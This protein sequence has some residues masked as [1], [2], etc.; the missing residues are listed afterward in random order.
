MMKKGKLLGVVLILCGFGALCGASLFMYKGYHAH[1]MKGSSVL[2]GIGV[3]GL[4][5]F[6]VL[7]GVGIY[8]FRKGR[9]EER[10][11]VRL[12]KQEKLLQPIQTLGKANLAKLLPELRLSEAEARNVLLSLVE[13]GLFSGYYH[14][15]TKTFYARDPN[16]VNSNTCPHCSGVREQ[17]GTGIIPCPYC[18]VD[19][20]I[21]HDTRQTKA[22]PIPPPQTLDP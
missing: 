10:D 12:K 2:F 18:K 13:E 1:T 15:Q 17:V 8:L 6:F 19:L 11:F 20:F 16:R 4:L 3:F 14:A 21:P 22:T 7:G 9:F 5:P